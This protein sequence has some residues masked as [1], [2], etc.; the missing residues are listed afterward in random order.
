ML[1]FIVVT[2]LLSNRVVVDIPQNAPDNLFIYDIGRNAIS[3]GCRSCL[4]QTRIKASE[5]Y[6]IGLEIRYPHWPRC[7]K[8]FILNKS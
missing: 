5:P 2:P 7:A 3:V 6:L 8:A 4:K 1:T